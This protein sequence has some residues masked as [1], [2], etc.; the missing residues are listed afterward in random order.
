MLKSLWWLVLIRGILAIVF[1]ILAIAFPV[2]TLVGLT[3]VFAAYSIVDGVA[4]IVHAIRTRDRNPRWGWLLFQGIVSV[5]A[6]IVAAVFPLVF[7]VFAA[8]VV[9]WIIAFWSLFAGIAGFPAAAATAD[10]G[11][12]VLAYIAAVLTIVFAILLMVILLLTP[13]DA[14][15][16]FVWVIG[17]Y[18]ITFG[19]A[20][21]VLAFTARSAL[22][23][24]T[25]DE[26]TPADTN[27]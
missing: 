26:P 4:A 25:K 6:G 18:A 15:V 16:G 8:A 27:V 3:I 1:G 21:I 10:G 9:L 22:T 20:L 23:D 17:A 12:K 11:R 14:V 13:A 2:L 5:L 19:V 24:A 7:G